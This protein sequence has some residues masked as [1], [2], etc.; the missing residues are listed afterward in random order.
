MFIQVRQNLG[1]SNIQM[2]K[3][4]ETE[5]FHRLVKVI[6][7]CSGNAYKSNKI[8]F[9]GTKQEPRAWRT[10]TWKSSGV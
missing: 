8:N 4:Y 3:S 7:K 1:L 6:R 10:V 9:T 2:I 5:L